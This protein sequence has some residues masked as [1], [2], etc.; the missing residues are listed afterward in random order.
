MIIIALI[1]WMQFM[2]QLQSYS[3]MYF[4]NPHDYCTWELLYSGFISSPLSHSRTIYDPY[5]IPH[6]LEILFYEGCWFPAC[7]QLFMALVLPIH[8][9]QMKY[10]MGNQFE[11]GIADI[12]SPRGHLCCLSL[13]SDQKRKR[14]LICTTVLFRCIH[15]SRL[16]LLKV[17]ASGMKWAC[18]MTSFLSIQWC[19]SPDFTEHSAE[20][21]RSEHCLS[22]MVVRSDPSS[23]L[24]LL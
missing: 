7:C 13:Q 19:H 18:L 12:P 23:N 1:Y 10:G 6:S 22:Q 24:Y 15:K 11:N 8:R 5:L 14:L 21:V 4:V 9:P 17:E 20:K 16:Q 3:C 2:C